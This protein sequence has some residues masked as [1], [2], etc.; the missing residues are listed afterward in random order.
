MIKYIKNISVFMLIVF[1]LIAGILCLNASSVYA[2]SKQ[3]NT[4]Y[5]S[6]LSSQEKLFYDTL[7][8]NYISTELMSGCAVMQVSLQEE[9]LQDYSISHNN[10]LMGSFLRAKLAFE[11]DY[12]QTSFIDFDKLSFN[13]VKDLNT[14]PAT[15]KA[16]ISSGK[17]ANYFA[18]GYTSKDQVLQMIDQTKTI[19][20]EYAT[21]LSQY[22]RID[23]KI[24]RLYTELIQKTTLT[25]DDELSG[26]NKN[27][28]NTAYSA[29][30]LNKSNPQGYAKTIKLVLDKLNIENVLVKGGVI[31]SDFTIYNSLYNY[32][33][34]N[35]KWYA[36]DASFDD[37]DQKLISQDAFLKG[38]ND[39]SKTHI[40]NKSLLSLTKQL[41]APTL[42]NT[43]YE[44]S[45]SFKVESLVGWESYVPPVRYSKFEVSFNNG[46]IS[47]LASQNLYVAV[48]HLEKNESN[49]LV[50]SDWYKVDMYMAKN[51]DLNKDHTN[52]FEIV[53][54]DY[55]IQFAVTNVD[56]QSLDQIY[57]VDQDNSGDK[58]YNYSLL[59]DFSE[60][61][62]FIYMSDMEKSVYKDK[63]ESLPLINSITPSANKYLKQDE[64]HEIVVVYDEP[65]R[66]DVDYTQEDIT[67]TL[68]SNKDSHLRS[69]IENVE[70]NGSN[71][72]AFTFTPSS[73]LKDNATTYSFQVEGLIGLYSGYKIQSFDYVV[74][75]P[76]KS[77]AKAQTFE[78]TYFVTNPIVLK[79]QNG[80]N[81]G[82]SPVDAN[83]DNLILIDNGVCKLDDAGIKQAIKQLDNK[84]SDINIYNL[85]LQLNKKQVFS[86]KLTL[87]FGYPNN[88][89]QN[90]TYKVYKVTPQTQGYQVGEVNNVCAE[91][92]IV[93]S[94][95][96]LGLYVVATT[97]NALSTKTIYA[98]VDNG[99]TTTQA[100]VFVVSGDINYEVTPKADFTISSI[101]LNG[102]SLEI[103]P[104]NF[105]VDTYVLPL[106]L[107]SLKQ[108]N[109]LVIQTCST[110][111]EQTMLTLNNEI[112]F[113]KY[114][115]QAVTIKV[116]PQSKK[117]TV[118]NQLVLEADVQKFTNATV[119]Y[120]WY[121]DG[122]PIEGATSKVYKTKVVQETKGEYYLVITSTFDGQV[123]KT[124]TTTAKIELN[125]YAVI[126][127]LVVFF[128]IV[129]ALSIF[130][131]VMNKKFK[132]PT[133][134]GEQ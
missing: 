129:I 48:R 127:F 36:I 64:S 108:T 126:Y 84:T 80:Y 57:F 47:T 28:A 120:Q 49:A 35:N 4:W 78:D 72:V 53:G 18:T 116:N 122:K 94:V 93:V 56:V 30:V 98:Y 61:E 68:S 83:Q 101:V 22:S 45:S 81:D 131:L 99:A 11:L 115:N 14:Q 26:E 60:T 39:F 118:G 97:T 117:L 132:I 37:H 110:Q 44:Y 128:V 71:E 25:F 67:V 1:S 20:E 54:G 125:N 63:E 96:E 58:A 113:D 41:V 8:Q 69:S 2:D 124:K 33:K 9:Y 3:S 59:T 17:Y 75:C 114:Y 19:V 133:K 31:N 15:L 109:T 76:P 23:S 102:N 27:Y 112:N 62:Y 123:L 50:W 121:K 10:S 77:I 106:V 91:F 7:K 104:A 70:W 85:Q 29:M 34:I 86:D 103:D 38:N 87:C 89:K 88:T 46:G 12:P 79:S 74:Y 51:P 73:L 95:D 32:V 92:G 52:Y 65:L 16:I 111:T 130:V 55:A 42:S 82:F 6:S 43:N 119:T 107:N 5:Y 21:T 100:D 40:E 105:N 134:Y 24:I 66:L 90:T 13:V